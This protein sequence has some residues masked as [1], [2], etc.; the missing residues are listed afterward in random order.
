MTKV[1]ILTDSSAYLPQE[2]V[3]RYGIVVLPMTLNWDGKSYRDG[4]D[5]LP[6]A[7]YNRLDNSD[8]LPTTSQVTVGEY[9]TLLE[10][11]VKSGRQVLMLP[12]SSGISGSYDSATQAVKDYSPD[13]VQLVDTKLVSMALSFQVLAAARHAAE[14]GSLAECKQTALDAYGKI[15][16]YFTV[17]TLKYLA[18]GGRI[19]S[20]RR[21]LGTALSI[22]PVLE[23]RDGKIELV[24]S[25]VTTKKA[26]ERMVTLVKEKTADKRP[27]RISVFHAGIPET[28]QALQDR[29]VAEMQPEEAILSQISPVIGSHTGPKTISIAYMVG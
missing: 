29:L 1:T 10:D 23:I 16:V 6:E 8:T 9:V 4:V 27:L 22:R 3:D 21:L 12:I 25:V 24:E 20:A 26:I 11:L 17:N 14:G 28:A 18:A 5:I 2:Y 13:Q 15:G 19:N 7:F